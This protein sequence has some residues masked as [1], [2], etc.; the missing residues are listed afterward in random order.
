ME[1]IEW[2]FRN[3]YV[4]VIVLFAL[5]SMFSKSKK[6]NQQRRPGQMPSFGNEAER[7]RQP[8]T[9]HVP[10]RTVVSPNGNGRDVYREHQTPPFVPIMEQREV[11]GDFASKAVEQRDLNAQLNQL[12]REIERLERKNK[13]MKRQLHHASS[14][15]ITRAAAPSQA[16]AVNGSK[17][18]QGV[19][20]AEVLGSPR[21]KRPYN[22]RNN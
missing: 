6:A 21:A 19:L 7:P 20:W 11:N 9:Q 2:V 17:L 5:F 10:Q 15:P 8:Q 4:V 1:F 13:E 14:K 3:L 16:F 22:H 12:N 18:A